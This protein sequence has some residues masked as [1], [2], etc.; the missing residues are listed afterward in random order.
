MSRTKT[1][2][3][4]AGAV[5]VVG[6]AYALMNRENWPIHQVSESNRLYS[7][8]LVSDYKKAGLD[9]SAR[10]STD[11]KSDGD[12]LN[13]GK[14]KHYRE[15]SRQT[16]DARGVPMIKYGKEF[17]YNPVTISQFILAEYGRSLQGGE[18]KKMMAAVNQL[19]K[20]QDAEGAFRY[21]FPYRHYTAVG[22]Y[23]PG[24]VSGMAQGVAL[25]ALARVYKKTKDPKYLDYGNRAVSFLTVPKD[26]GG[27]FV[28]MA[29]LDKSLKDYV[30]FEEYLT[31]PNVYT[32]NG[33]MFTLLGLYDWADITGSEQA[34]KLFNDGMKTLEKILPYYDIGSFSAYDLSYITHKRPSYLQELKPH[35]VVRY[36]AV[37]ITQLAALTSITNNE[38]IKKFL[39]KWQ[40]DVK[41]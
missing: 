20:L 5:V 26:Q 38:T 13:Y 8:K 16:F 30:F 7:E 33:Y 32:L 3:I 15:A 28:S 10:I 17:Q 36:H 9:A 37:H 40:N 19:L 31:T 34:K 41:E 35:G 12:Y 24:W 6:T 25:S 4:I 39:E 1:S 21:Y 11:Y 2:Y 23:K 14:T 18:E 27:P 22:L 29:D